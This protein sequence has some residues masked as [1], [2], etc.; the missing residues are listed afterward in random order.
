M[1]TIVKI[2]LLVAMLIGCYLLFTGCDDCNCEKH[3]STIILNYKDDK[4][5]S[6]TILV[7]YW[8]DLSINSDD[9]YDQKTNKLAV[10]IKSYS[11]LDDVIISPK[12]SKRS[13]HHK[14][15]DKKKDKDS[16]DDPDDNNK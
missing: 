14:E 2:H 8:G 4:V 15:K 13:K 11:I 3:K 9:L 6:D 12:E 1:K 16:S 5:E 10:N 7:T